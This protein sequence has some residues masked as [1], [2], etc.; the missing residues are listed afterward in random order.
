MRERKRGNNELA[1]LS[2]GGRWARDEEEEE[3]E[4][5]TVTERR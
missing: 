2:F 4:R 5:D 3:E 1:D